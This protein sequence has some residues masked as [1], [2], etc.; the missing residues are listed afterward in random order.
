LIK[1]ALSIHRGQIPPSLHFTTPNPHIAFEDLKLRVQ[2]RLEP[3]PADRNPIAGVSS[4]GFGG[5]NAHAVLT[6]PPV[7]ATSAAA[8]PGWPSRI[9][10]LS[11]RSPEALRTLAERWAPWLRQI[12]ANE[13]PA[14]RFDDICFTA[15]RRRSHLDYRLA[16]VAR[17]FDT[18]SRAL[19]EFAAGEPTGSIVAGTARQT[20][21]RL[22]FVCPGQ[23]GQWAGMGRQLMAEAATFRVSISRVG[24]AFRKFVDWDLAAVIGAAELP[25]RIDIVQPALFAMSVAF[26]D[27]WRSLGIEPAAVVGHSMGEVAA[28]HIAGVLTLEDAAA[29]ICLRSQLLREISGGGAMAV[30]ELSPD[31]IHSRLRGAAGALSLAAIN[32][33]NSVVVAGESK[34]IDALVER[35]ELE[36]VFCRAI[37][38][39]VASHSAQVDS[40]LPALRKSL[41]SIRPGAARIPLYSTVTGTPL[42]GP[43]MDAEYWARNL[44]EPVVFGPTVERLQREGHDAFVELGPHPV[45]SHAVTECRAATGFDVLTVPSLRREADSCA[46][47]LSGLGQLFVSG[48]PIDWSRVYA[49]PRP[50]VSLPGYAWQRQRFWLE[51]RGSTPI[52]L[53]DG[54]GDRLL[55]ATHP[56]LGSPLQLASDSGMAVWRQR[57]SLDRLPYLAD[58]RVRGHCLLPASAYVEMAAAAALD[59]AGAGPIS[60]RHVRFEEALPISESSGAIVELVADVE[61]GDEASFRISSVYSEG[62]ES[63]QQPR[64]LLHASGRIGRR[65]SET[66][67]ASESDSLAMLQ[68]R[69]SE[70]VDLQEFYARLSRRNLEYGPAFRNVMAIWRAEGESLARL[71]VP[72]SRKAYR[73][74]PALLDAGFQCLSAALPGNGQEDHDLFLP[75]GIDEVNMVSARTEGDSM[76]AYARVRKDDRAV[77]G[78]LTGDVILFDAAGEP[79]AVVRCLRLRRTRTSALGPEWQRIANWFHETTWAEQVLIERDAAPED[80][81]TWIVL[82]HAGSPFESELGACLARTKQRVVFVAPGDAFESVS[83]RRYRVNPREPADFRRLLGAVQQAESADAAAVIDAWGLSST[84]ESRLTPALLMEAVT[85]TTGAALH[86]VQAL[87]SLSARDA[88]RLYLVTAGVAHTTGD[89]EWTLA[90]ATLEGF[91]RTVRLEHPELRCTTIDLPARPGTADIDALVAECVI[92]APETEVALREGR[93]FIARL[94]AAPPS[95]APPG[96]AAATSLDGPYSLR[97]DDV[98]SLDSLHLVPT[99]RRRP[100]PLEVE[101]AVAA[102]GLN[103]LDV[104]SAIGTRPDD[105]VG[106]PALGVECAGFVVSIGSGVSDLSAGDEVIAI[107]PDATSAYVITRRALVV[108]KPA[109]LDMAAAAAVPIAFATAGHALRHLARLRPGERVLIHSAAT[110]TGLAALH[111]ARELGGIVFATAGLEEKRAYLRGLGV[112]HVFDSRSLE[113]VDGVREVTN[114][115][116]V[117]AIVNSLAGDAIP[118]GLSLLRSRGRFIEIGKRDV[119]ANRRLGLYAL[120]RNISVSVVDLAHLAADDP[121]YVGSLVREALDSIRG[122]RL[123]ELPCEEFPIHDAARAFRRMAQ[124]RHIGKIVLTHGRAAASDAPAPSPAAPTRVRSDSVGSNVRPDRTYLITGG[125]GAIGTRV[126]EYLSANGAGHIALLGRTVPTDNAWSSIVA[127]CGKGTDVS[128]LAVDVADPDELQKALTRIEETMPPVAGI[129][130]AAGVLEDGLLAHQTI[131]RFTRVMSPKVLGAWNL[132]TLTIGRPLDH[133]VLFSSAAAVVGSPGQAGYAA[134][135]SFLGQLARYRRALGLPALAISWGPWA[136]AG[137]A[138]RADRQGRLANRGLDA[139]APDDG[140]RALSWAMHDDAVEI[141]VAPFN[142]RQWQQ[143]YPRAADASLF[144]ELEID[145][146]VSSGRAETGDAPTREALLAL[147]DPKQRYDLIDDRLRREIARVLHITPAQMIDVTSLDSLG[148]D[149]LLALELRNRLES[150]FHVHLSATLVWSHPSVPALVQ[151]LATAMNVPLTA[152]EDEPHARARADASDQWREPDQTAMLVEQLSDE[153]ALREL[154]G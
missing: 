12:S 67:L 60:L 135:N 141:M 85:F 11:A 86:L 84:G 154:M 37:S 8:P 96:P 6:A 99:A 91:S 2:T 56:L 4:F 131:E 21:P 103:F 116:G 27:L 119:Y 137:L 20:P 115:E 23:G 34:A 147:A 108:G 136:D 9:L 30:V 123:P 133:F 59:S 26:A 111:V 148:F 81:R 93:R 7:R 14:G 57:L 117:D 48:Y 1:V 66:A 78:T 72:R 126:A 22:A 36:Q 150:V 121:E 19:E 44:R 112:E 153:D 76:W 71:A 41:S 46:T 33:P 70:P 105:D 45:L 107:A 40:L 54:A 82:A 58:H 122:G 83:P 92:A 73:L 16:V 109:G 144:A 142:V 62:T 13:Q 151:Y 139:I 61:P 128:F 138:A 38:V 89:S 35:L 74:H 95:A 97:V 65:I 90:S 47:I 110:G 88:A 127:A 77:E 80:S 68:Q 104:L 145:R 15:A 50:V 129:F 39:D 29:V 43:E 79:I 114:G 113:F 52:P 140:I 106:S 149:S 75:S 101:I 31:E 120:R 125:A 63:N 5:T 3:W 49:E 28:A 25:D 17:T 124:G 42:R 18:A 87:T 10:P 24:D 134:G 102:T 55:P 130:H 51:Q 94:H 98:G 100:G 53:S 32:S 69:V 132:H 118:A 143:F 64:R 146:P 152:L